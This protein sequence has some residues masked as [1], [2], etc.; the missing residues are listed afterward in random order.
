MLQVSCPVAVVL[1]VTAAALT[2]ISSVGAA[3]GRTV[4]CTA[5]TT[6]ALVRSF[7]ADYDQGRVAAINRMWA[8]EPYFQWFSTRAPGGRSGAQAYDRATLVAHFRARVRAHER[9][10]L[11]Q[12]EAGYDPT[13][14]IVNFGGYLLRSADDIHSP[15]RHSFKGAADCRS[16]SPSLIVW[17]M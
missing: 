8:P 3:P 13:R 1:A 6:K 16:G 4:A 15:A 12:L 14:D 7:V 5:A 17:S 2:P 11:T 10:V 9:L